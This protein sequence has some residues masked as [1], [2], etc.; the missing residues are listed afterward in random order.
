[1]RSLI[2]TCL[3]EADKRGLSSIAFPPI[4]TWNLGYPRDKVARLFFEEVDT[5]KKNHP[6]TSI[7][8][9]H[10]VMFQKDTS[11]IQAFENEQENR[12]KHKRAGNANSMKVFASDNKDLDSAD[13]AIRELINE[14]SKKKSIN[15]AAIKELSQAQE[16]RI[17]RLQ[18]KYSTE[19]VIERRI[20]RI[21]VSGVSDD[22][23]DAV[24]GKLWF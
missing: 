7:L 12:E 1:M 15:H 9:V 8:E 24:L 14:L 16:D 5:F 22:V 13:R 18:A 10:I 23:S 3:K 6:K 20:G 11:T 21:V 2:D 17:G 19:I 4:G